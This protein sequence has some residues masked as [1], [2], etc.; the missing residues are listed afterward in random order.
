MGGSKLG[1]HCFSRSSSSLF[2]RVSEVQAARPLLLGQIIEEAAFGP[3]NGRR[4]LGT[5]GGDRESPNV[6]LFR[7]DF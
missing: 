5:P 1:A 2:G 6:P 7:L 3:G 4:I